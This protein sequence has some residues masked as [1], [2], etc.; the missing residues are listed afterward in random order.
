MQIGPVVN[1]TFRFVNEEMQRKQLLLFLGGSVVAFILEMLASLFNG[2]FSII[3]SRIWFLS[4]IAFALFFIAV[5]VKQ[6]ID[7]VRGRKFFLPVIFL[8]VFAFFAFQIG[9]FYFSDLSYESTQE[10]VSG[11]NAFEQ[12][13][14]NYT[15]TGFTGYPIKQYLIN[16]IPTIIFGRS[17]F[18]L[19][20][21]FALPFL[22][23]LTL[24]FIELRKFLTKIGIDEKFSILPIFMISFCPLVDEFY[25]IFEQTLTPVC[26][27][28]I[29]IALFLRFIR[30]RTFLSVSMLTISACMLP[31]LYT[32]ALA[33]LGL[34]TVIMLYHALLGFIGRSRYVD[35]EK[36]NQN[37]LF[38]ALASGI[39]PV[40]FFCCTVVAKRNDRFLSGYGDNY[41]A[42]KQGEY[43]KAFARFFVDGDSIFWGVFGAVILIYLIASL[44]FRFKLHDAVIA[45]WAIVTAFMSFMLPGVAILFN[46]FYVP[47]SL[48]QRSMVIV[49]VLAVSSL[50][51]LTGFIR[52]HTVRIRND[53]LAVFSVAFML[54]GVNSLF[55]THTACEYNNYIQHMKYIVKYCQEATERYGTAYDDEFVIEVHTQNNLLQHAWDF[56]GYFFPNAKIYVFPTEQFGGISIYDTIFPKYIFSESE[57]T[58]NYYYSKFSLQ[59][60]K[61][62]RFDEDTKIYF[63]YFGPDFSYVDQYDDAYIIKYNLQQYK[64]T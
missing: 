61:N 31:F 30:N 29:V 23:G 9:N 34:F 11:L 8:F 21:G 44:T 47:A 20:L 36:K 22:M 32:P 4:I 26:Y 64:H 27:T 53:A 33:F 18:S 55:S 28:M 43:I 7:D 17:F 60:Y 41:S 6:V 3:A 45:L 14:W 46:F 59:E 57:T 62:V 40:L 49:P 16:A 12:P 10:V 39:M 5:V 35:R 2:Y 15:G 37:Y 54:F 25:Y 24:L 42:E 13:D 38:A 58:E 51:A 19:N 1:K 63:G 48:A 52:K 56:T 50:F